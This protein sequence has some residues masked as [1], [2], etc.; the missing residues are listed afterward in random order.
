MKMMKYFL[1][2]IC[3]LLATVAMAQ[4]RTLTGTVI[5]GGGLNE[6]LFGANVTIVN[7]Q[8]RTLTGATTD[9]DGNFVITNVPDGK[10]LRIQVS[11]IG[12]KM[13]TL[14]YTGQRSI[15]VTLESDSKMLSDVEVVTKA[16]SR[17]E[18]GITDLQQTSSTQKV[19]MSEITDVAPVASIE[20]ALQGQM[21]GV[22]IV[23]GGDPGSKSSIRIRGVSTLSSSAEPLVVV[24]G[25]PTSVSFGD[26]FSFSDANEDDFGA[27]LNISPADI[28]SIEVLKDAS[29]TSIYG[30]SGANGVLLINTKQGKTGKTTFNFQSKYSYKQEPSTIPLLNG[31]QYISMIEDAIWNAANAKGLGNAASELAL[32][33]DTKELLRDKTYRYYNEYNV[34]TDWLDEVRQNAWQWDNSFSVSGGGNKATYRV[35]LGYLDDVGTTIG[36]EARRITANA[37]VTYKFSDQFRVYTDFS[38]TDYNKD[39]N[40][41]D[42]VR[43][44]AQNMMPNQSP[45]L[46]NDDGTRSDSYFT[47]N[48]NFQGSYTGLGKGNW[49]PVAMANESYKNTRERNEKMTINWEYKVPFKDHARQLKYEGWVSLN[50]KTSATKLFVPQEAT[51][52]ILTSS[53]SNYSSESSS[54]AMSLQTQNKIMYT[55][56]LAEKHSIVATALVRTTANNSASASSSTYGNVSLNLSDPIVGSVVSSAGSGDSQSR[57][58]Q[59][60][61]L[62]NYTYDNRYVLNATFTQE[63]NSS[64]GKENR[65]GVFPAF[66]A[67]WNVDREHWFDDV[68]WMTIGKVRASLGWSGNPPT[69]AYSYL[70]AYNTLGTY[71]NLNALYPS[72]IQLD[73]L[74]WESTREW[75]LGLDFRIFDR[76]GMTFD[77]YDKY[78]SDCLM[79]KVSI[80]S[81]SG[82]SQLAYLNSGEVSNKGY[83]LRFD[84]DI[85]RNKMWYI[86]GSV[87]GSRNINKIE[88]IPINYT[89]ESY[90]FNN[91]NYAVRIVEGDPVGSFYGY[92]YKGVYQN[93]ED[94]YAIDASGNIMRDFNGEV[95]SM[96]NGKE[97]VYPGDAKYEDINHDGVI[98]EQD[99]VYLGNSNPTF[100]GGGNF[101]VKYGNPNAKAGVFTFSMNCNFRIGQKVINQARMSLESMYGTSNQSTAV[102]SRWRKEGDKTDIPRALYGMGYNYLGS[103]RF[104]E[105]ASYCRIK[106]LSLAWTMPKRMTKNLHINSFQF[107]VT[108]YDLFTFTNYSGQNPEVSLPS[109]STA[110]VK[111]SSKSPVTKRYACGINLSF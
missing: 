2:A 34:N 78:T 24:D 9:L 57:K 106:T 58:V 51:G 86:K 27:L 50:M 33:F 53:L 61:E 79:S 12:L 37:R 28:E 43:S 74:K 36:T 73:K 6:P 110:L 47:P 19:Q 68:D 66:G 16:V 96:R 31:K 35:S 5:E 42:N 105:D 13:Q 4:N 21:A 82:Y 63:G 72:R 103:D 8:N 65:F 39:A 38:Y 10:N 15:T 100:I 89:E 84:F 40:A 104:V 23:L 90:T 11:F 87:N 80:P 14:N 29:A 46:I 111:D 64:M 69:G 94:T 18:L 59:F 97:R 101:S 62:V 71:M 56:T 22:D 67:S 109:T 81:T 52:V 26:D 95:V 88:K 54:D 17:S 93:T 41:V 32:L 75:D 92:R 70:G 45:Y 77:Y 30:T 7:A 107:F 48:S 20:E 102:L 49:N 55:Q 76:F 1:T 108:G 44:Q 83:E 25:I 3:G 60:T 85:F 99:I 91:G 98:N